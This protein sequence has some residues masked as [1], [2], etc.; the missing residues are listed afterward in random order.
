MN[1]LKNLPS[2]TAPAIQR[3]QGRVATIHELRVD[4]AEDSLADS[5][6]SRCR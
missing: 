6:V 3:M 5:R 1:Y 2:M 4:R